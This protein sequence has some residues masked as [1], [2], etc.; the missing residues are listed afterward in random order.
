MPTIGIHS[1][2]QSGPLEKRNPSTKETTYSTSHFNTA[3]AIPA[4]TP[5]MTEI[6]NNL[7]FPDALVMNLRRVFVGTSASSTYCRDFDCDDFS[8]LSV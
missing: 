7:T 5:I 6:T 3:A 4:I 8:I 2:D 1:I